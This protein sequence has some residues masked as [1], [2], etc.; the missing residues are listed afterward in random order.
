M[1]DINRQTLSNEY[2]QILLLLPFLFHSI[3][4]T[5][6]LNN[7]SKQFQDL[8]VIQRTDTRQLL[9]LEQEKNTNKRKKGA[10][11]CLSNNS[12][13]YRKYGRTSYSF[14]CANDIFQRAQ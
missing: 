3:S 10:T 5:K 8:T 14:V 6:Q 2:S 1:S 11:T 4:T 9:N 7:L 13:R 12:D